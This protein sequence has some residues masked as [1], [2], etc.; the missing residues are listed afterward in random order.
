MPILQISNATTV[1]YHIPELSF[2]TIRVYD[3]LRNEI[4]TLVNKERPE[5]GYE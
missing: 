5:G 3:V 2:V 1:K 4:E